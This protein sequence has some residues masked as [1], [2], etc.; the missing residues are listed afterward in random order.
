MKKFL[1][2]ISIARPDHWFKNVFMLPGILLA[3]LFSDTTFELSS[4][5]QII[6][7]IFATCLIASAN[8]TIN[9]WLDAPFD[10]EHPIKKDR[11]AACGQIKPSLAYLQYALLSVIGLGISYSINVPFCLTNAFLLFMG[12]MYNVPPI[13]TKDIPYLDVVSESVNNAIRL[14][15][16]WYLVIDNM[17]PP[18]SII[19][20][21]WMLGAFFMAMKRLGE[22]RFIQDNNVVKTYRKSLAYYTQEKLIT[23]IIFYSSLFSFTSAIFLIRYKFELILVIPLLS[24][25]IAEYM[26]IGFLPD[27]PVQYPEKL[28][29]QKGLVLICFLCLALFTFLLFV[30]IPWLSAM[31]DPLY[32]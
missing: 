8:Y 9:E 27:S 30:K 19:I 3:Y 26:R 32:K 31:F 4:L 18:L 20:A 11:P 12:L 23:S 10:R 2:Y 29:K 16:G 5:P 28:Y 6:W 17:L 21:Y 25:L 24:L 1:P 22:I 7:G 13:R 15:L 14:M